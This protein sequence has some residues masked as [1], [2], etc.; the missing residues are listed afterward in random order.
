MTKN[1]DKEDLNYLQMAGT[2]ISDF[3]G[4]LVGKDDRKAQG[5]LGSYSLRYDVVKSKGNTLTVTYH[6][7]TDIDN[8][9]LI[10]GHMGWQKV[11]NGTPQ[12]TGGFFAGYRVEVDW[13]ETIYK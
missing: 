9:S 4:L 6:A 3:G 7:W 1:R 10:P 5:I 8:E 11:F 12:Y 13:Q 2:Y